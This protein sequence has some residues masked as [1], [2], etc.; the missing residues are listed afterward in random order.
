MDSKQI[1]EA[2]QW[3]EGMLL[4]PQHLQQLSQRSES[5]VHYHLH[6]VAPFFWGI[7]HLE[8]DQKL[9]TTGVFR[10]LKLEAVMPDGLVVSHQAGQ[11]T[12]LQIA[13][14][15][16]N[17]PM[18]IHL[19]VPARSLVATKGDL[20]R[21]HSVEGEPIV[22]ESTGDGEVT[23]P[24][25]KPQLRLFSGDVPPAKFVSFPLAR[26]QY[27][28]EAFGLTDFIPPSTLVPIGSAIWEMCS[29][30][31]AKIRE[32]ALFLSEQV[33][34]PASASRV[35]LMLETKNRIQSLVCGLPQFEAVMN[36]GVVH[37][38]ELYKA[39]CVLAGHLAALGYSMVPPVFATYK[40]NDLYASFN[41]LQEFAFTMMEE[42]IPESY[43]AIPLQLV[44]KMFSVVFDGEWKDRRLFL[45]MR[46]PT[47]MSEKDV[48]EWGEHCR[49]GSESVMRSMREKRILGAG[50]QLIQSYEALVPARGVIL[51]ALEYDPQFIRLDE[52]L[53]VVNDNEAAGLHPAE[54]ILY[55]KNTMADSAVA[56]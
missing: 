53:Q 38:F 20:P 14:Q 3:H 40:H 9:L 7:R 51:F 6:S 34:S 35:P 54:V 43:I 5:L 49:I 50:R 17:Q 33:R 28:N 22:D 15:N 52:V 55:V 42:G 32:R 26:V 46:G 29:L 44:R 1:P 23:I 36:T 12:D 8:F 31:A 56:L 18:T 10:V 16:L 11:S 4:A 41:Q 19:A 37:P 13:L 25:L 47:G 21:Y 45:A 24:R 2:I 39:F 48:V 27:R 30:T